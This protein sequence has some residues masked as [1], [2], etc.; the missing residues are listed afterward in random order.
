[1]I[2]A[3]KRTVV[4]V[5]TALLLWA[6]AATAAT[7]PAGAAPADPNVAV[8]VA[9]ANPDTVTDPDP[10]HT[11]LA[12]PTHPY[13]PPA[14]GLH[15]SFYPW[16]GNRGYDVT[17]YD[18]RL[19]V[20][21][22]TNTLDGWTGIDAVAE[23]TLD[24]FYLDLAG[25]EVTAVEVDDA[26]A[27]FSRIEDELRVTPAAPIPAGSGFTVAVST[28]GSPQPLADRGVPFTSLGWFSRDGVIYTANEPSGAMSWFP[29]N[30][31]PTDKATFQITIN[32]PEH[33]TAASNGL[34]VSETVEDGRRTAVWQMN[35]PM[36]TYL[37][38]VYI[39][40]FDRHS[41][42]LRDDLL[43][44][45]YIPASF[46]SQQTRATLDK[47]AVT[48]DAIEYFEGILGPYPYDAYGTI[49]L[50]FSTG[51][52]LE[53]QTLSVHG[54]W[55][56]SSRV[57]A[58]ELVH[59]WIGNSVTAN[60]WSDVWLHEGF[61]HYLSLMYEAH[62]SGADLNTRM[63]RELS[64]AIAA[65]AGPPADI[66]I[67]QMFDFRV[68]YQR[69]ALALHDLHRHLGDD[70]FG[71]LLR[72]HYDYSAGGTTHTDEFLY[73]VN[74]AGGWQAAAVIMPWLY[75]THIP[76]GFTG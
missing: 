31:H 62:V 9:V 2:A 48:Q 53:N 63:A 24:E 35:D 66:T 39:G 52:A 33:L 29:S 7:G 74:E 23:T 44:R 5:A 4:V 76:S 15:D 49:V 58:H 40:D 28:A 37:A 8:A 45:N 30:N 26:P 14:A 46:N 57:I 38:A 32:V 42:R 50:P 34:L 13:L 71:R 61:A 25:L 3:V 73:F 36:A 67:S 59:Q 10:S 21:P 72:R 70:A 69:G 19:T 17:H 51:F 64:A 22:A 68:T 27:E 75:N 12:I 11:A 65:G 18:L 1:M 20:E 6:T 55:M 43:I 54:R 16:M 41:Q 56:L 47:L 60:D